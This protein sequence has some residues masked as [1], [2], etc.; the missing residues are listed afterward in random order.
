MSVAVKSYKVVEEE[1]VEGLNLEVG[2]A[3]G[4]GWEPIG[5]HKV[6]FGTVEEGGEFKEIKAWYSQTLIVPKPT[7]TLTKLKRQRR[8]DAR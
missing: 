7:L 3:I 2:H 5:S 4:E 1:T 8:G 6:V